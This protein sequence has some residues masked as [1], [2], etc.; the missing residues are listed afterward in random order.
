MKKL[1]LINLFFLYLAPSFQL[2][3]QNVYTA[4][5]YN[6]RIRKVTPA[7]VISTVAGTGVAGFSGDGGQ[8]TAAQ[9]SQPSDVSWCVATGSLYICDEVNER[10]RKVNSSGV[11]STF[12]GNGV[13]GYSGDGGPATAAE[14][15]YP[16]GVLYDN[17]TGNVY[18]A[19]FRGARVRKINPAGI[20]T[21]YA[22]Q[23]TMGYS[24][25]GGP[26]TAAELNAPLKIALDNAGNLYIADAYNNRIR[27]VTPAGIISTYAGT[28]VS[29]FSGDGG[30]A[31]AATLNWTFGVGCDGTNVYPCD[32]S[33]QRVRVIYP[34]G[35]INTI[36]GNG[37]GGFNSD[38]TPA[39]IKELWD[40][41]QIACDA[42]GVFHISEYENQRLRNLTGTNIVTIAGNGTA[43]Y[44][45]DGSPS[46]TKTLDCPYGIC[47]DNPPVV[48]PVS[49]SSFKADY[50]QQNNS[51]LC[52]WAVATQTNNKLFTVEKSVD[53]QMWNELG[54]V[55]G[56]G[57]V[58]Y[59][60]DY[61]LTD[62][63]PTM[64]TSYYRLTQTDFDGKETVYAPVAINVDAVS[65]ATLYPNPVKES[66]T[67]AYYSAVN[68]P[69]TITV[70]DMLGRTVRT[71]TPTVQTGN[72]AIT[73]S[74]SDLAK[75]IY[76]MR[77]I[78]SAQNS[79]IRF[80]KD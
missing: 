71:V 39:T 15:Y 50:V 40:P 20:I 69:I 56:G 62:Y 38:G 35:I 1:L 75:G 77:I 28:G 13:L 52:Q 8:A 48:L 57:T 54:T 58:S 21:T 5:Y 29:G 19:E 25:D 42:S 78:G 49:L 45:G 44:N 10:I 33:N 14:M 36:A 34:S 51:V 53:G 67:L 66:A 18:V 11:M 59:S 60:Q 7:G 12:A 74:T 80:I 17:V 70:M 37:T 46:T 3:A 61:S 22:G 63:Q 55:P 32:F 41:S 16:F 73:I 31:T 6:D 4:D 68:E 79:C 9:V 23:G 24:G 27:K 47:V 43:G 64:G 30:Q 65:E 26:A 72:N 76:F 2:K